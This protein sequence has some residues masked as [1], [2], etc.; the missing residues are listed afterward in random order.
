MIS[1]SGLVTWYT[2]R[3]LAR[4]MEVDRSLIT[5]ADVGWYT[6]VARILMQAGI[7]S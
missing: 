3:I 5:Y 1:L 7:R 2:A 4:C 6:N